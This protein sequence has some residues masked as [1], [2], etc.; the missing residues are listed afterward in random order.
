MF[1]SLSRPFARLIESRAQSNA[2]AVLEGVREEAQKWRPRG[3]R[4]LSIKRR[5]YYEGRQVAYLRA[6]LR[7]RNPVRGGEMTPNVF[8]Y[9]RLV[10]AQNADIMSGEPMYQTSREGAE[11]AFNQLMRRVRLTRVLK[12]NER[13]KEAARS[14][15]LRVMFN[16]VMERVQVDSFWPSDV[17]IVP[18]PGA[19]T[20][21]EHA[22]AIVARVSGA[23]G[24]SKDTFEVWTKETLEDGAPYTVTRIDEDGNETPVLE[25]GDMMTWPL[26]RHPFV[27]WH[28]ADP[29]GLPYLD[30]DHDLTD[31]QDGINTDWTLLGEM[32]RFQAASALVYEGTD[33]KPLYAG[34]GL[35]TRVNPGEDLRV[36]D[37]NA[38]LDEVRESI[39]TKTRALAVTRRQ[40]PDA[41]AEEPGP[42]LSGVSRRIQNQPQEEA[43]QERLD[44]TK[45]MIEERLLP[46]VCEVSDVFGGTRIHAPDAEYTFMP[47]DEPA[48]EDP[49]I[50]QRRVLEL[51]AERMI[52]KER[53]AVELGIYE[54]EEEAREAIEQLRPA[55]PGVPPQEAG[56]FGAQVL[57]E[58]SGGGD[59]G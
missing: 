13:R 49:D 36:L 12:E 57:G 44:V 33:D 7:E 17:D 45:E 28:A 25:S 56:S 10:A 11:E 14:I 19:P 27:A 39:K 20:S 50:R 38:K 16:P 53:A 24:V 48:F 55:R 4:G 1:E 30:D 8:N 18:H 9:F 54:T 35:A 5:D 2:L 43:R 46:L 6:L 47:D 34:A 15:F 41:Y 31:V 52:S 58:L 23:H 21:T 51:L 26:D 42:P 3:H 29:D 22:I 37:F 32:V 40:N 59:A